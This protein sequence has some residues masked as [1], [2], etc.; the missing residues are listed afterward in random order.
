MAKERFWYTR[1]KQVGIVEK[2]G[3]NVTKNG[4]TTPY[5]SV[6]EAKELRLYTISVDDDLGST[7]IDDCYP[8]IPAQYHETILFKA[9][10]YGYLDPR[11]LDVNAAGSFTQ[12][13]SEGVKRAKKYVKSQNITTGHIVPAEF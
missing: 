7:L 5:K 11:N 8:L 10:S 13:Y 4:V 2:D 3:T 1:N 12:L 6:S 9:I